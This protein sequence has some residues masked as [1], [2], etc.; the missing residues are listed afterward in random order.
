MLLTGANNYV[1]RHLMQHHPD[2]YGWL[3]Q[4]RSYY[5][6]RLAPD[7]RV[8]W[9][10]DNDAF[11]TFHAGRFTKALEYM[12]QYE[13]RCLFV[14]CPDSV[15]N[16]G[17]TLNLWREWQ[18]R[19][20]ALNLPCAFVA[21]DGLS[22]SEVPWS[23][24]D[25]LFVGGTDHFKD[26]QS[27]DVVLE[28]KRRRLWVHVGRVN[29]SERRLR[30][31]LELDVNSIDGTVYGRIPRIALRWYLNQRTQYATQRRLL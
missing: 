28:A 2:E 31:C 12:A 15:G 9:A 14:V 26:R 8:R 22:L 19:I 4:P 7:E 18:P 23:E 17:E 29:Q 21:Q 24:M 6:N 16:H 27:R 25:A 11:N 13:D 10:M 30:Y 1:Y 20:K 5:R 3:M